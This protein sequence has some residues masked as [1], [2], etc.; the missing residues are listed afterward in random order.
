[1]G[2]EDIRCRIMEEELETFWPQWH[3]VKRLGGGAFGDVFEIFRDNHGV[4]MY[5]ALKVLR[6][7]DREAAYGCGGGITLARL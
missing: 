7:S 4:P 6:I 2:T 3:V 1:M 5:S